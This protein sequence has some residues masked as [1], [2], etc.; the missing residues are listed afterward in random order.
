MQLKKK[1]LK[2]IY[3]YIYDQK[4]MH[5]VVFRTTPLGFKYICISK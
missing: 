5:Q 2:F 4:V 1:S 3:I